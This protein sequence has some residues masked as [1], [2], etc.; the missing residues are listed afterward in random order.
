[1]DTILLTLNKYVQKAW[2][3]YHELV[4]RHHI[5]AA[6]AL[7]GQ[8][9]RMGAHC[10]TERRSPP[11]ARTIAARGISIEGLRKLLQLVAD[12]LQKNPSAVLTSELRQFVVEQTLGASFTKPCPYHEKVEAKYKGEPAAFVSYW[13]GSSFKGLVDALEVHFSNARSTAVWVDLIA[14]NQH[15]ACLES[16][17]KTLPD[18][19]S[20]IGMT[21]LFLD[22]GE[23]LRRLWCAFEIFFSMPGRPGTVQKQ[24]KV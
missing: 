17:L 24:V 20:E 16:D 8:G 19:I 4:T 22:S 1:M 5:S 6:R 14:L 13:S 9:E 2:F 21:L 3:L 15:E 7:G 10:G 18:V 12:T 23:C 11:D